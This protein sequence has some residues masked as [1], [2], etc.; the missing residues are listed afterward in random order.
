MRVLGVLVVVVL[1][2]VGC[3]GRGGVVESSFPSVSSS[4]VSPSV[5]VVVS[6]SVFESF[7]SVVGES[8]DRAAV[9]AGWLEYW[10][11]YDKF[12]RDPTL[13]DLSETQYVTTGE[14]SSVIVRAIRTYREQGLRSAGGIRFSKISVGTP[15][16]GDSARSAIITY[17]T[18]NAEYKVY[19]DGKPF[20]VEKFV[21][22]ETATM[23]EGEDGK[24]RVAQIRNERDPSC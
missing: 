14:M 13:T 3:S 11:V 17:C 4:V 6:P 8:G 16:A 19:K 23:L 9:R 7:P 20:D 2:A 15:T 1:L 5:S 22:R 21:L 18:D 12:T 10:R 24:W